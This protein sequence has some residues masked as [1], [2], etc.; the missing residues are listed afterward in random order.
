MSSSVSPSTPRR[1]CINYG[2]SAVEA[3][4]L[5][6]LIMEV[7]MLHSLCFYIDGSIESGFSFNKVT[8]LTSVDYSKVDASKMETVTDVA[9]INAAVAK[10]SGYAQRS[11]WRLLHNLPKSDLGSFFIPSA[12]LLLLFSEI[13]VFTDDRFSSNLGCCCVLTHCTDDKGQEGYFLEP[14]AN[15]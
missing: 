3:E 6:K 15:E 13:S 12:V 7:D 2:V 9:S 11:F 8:L 10:N 4:V 14:C 5:H 1:V